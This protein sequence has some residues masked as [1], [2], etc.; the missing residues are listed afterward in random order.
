MATPN[1][2]RNT[3]ALNSDLY[4]TPHWAVA[5]LLKREKFSGLIR[6]PGCGKGDIS[7]VLKM[8][9]HQSVESI[10]LYDWGYGTPNIDYLDLDS[11]VDNT[12]MNPPF[13]LLKEFISKALSTT[14]QKVAVFARVNS[15]ETKDRFNGIYKEKPPTRVYLFVHRVKCNKGGYD[16][17]LSSAVFYCWQVWDLSVDSNVTELHWIDDQCPKEEKPKSVLTA[18]AIH[19]SD[20]K[21]LLDETIAA[22]RTSFCADDMERE[23]IV[24]VSGG[25]DSTVTKAICNIATEGR[26]RAIFCDTDNEHPD[27][28]E[29]I[30]TLH[31]NIGSGSQPVEMYKLEIPESRF[32]YRRKR[33]RETWAKPYVIRQGVYAGEVIPPMTDEQIELAVSLTK[34][35]GNV[36]FDLCI[37]H[38]SM[39]TR[40]ARFCTRELKIEVSQHQVLEIALSECDGEVINWSGVRAE[41]SVKRSTYNWLSEDPR[42]DGFLFTF[43]PIHK[44]KVQDVFALHKY[45]GI[46]P[47]PLY[48]QGA[49]R[50]GCWP[51]IMSNKAEIRQFAQDEEAVQRIAQIERVIKHLNRYSYWRADKEGVPFKDFNTGFF[52]PRAGMV[53]VGIH[54]VIKWAMTDRKGEP[55]EYDGSVMNCQFGEHIFCE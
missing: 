47:N 3:D 20:V 30:K 39:P 42:G 7:K 25:K 36:F 31:D 18:P 49:D 48:L 46:E 33:I 5:A 43:L 13:S 28:Y 41:E 35:T 51:C 27:T 53:G 26:Y 14:N 8:T 21:T 24:S 16:N 19:F 38:G 45:L 2:K 15:L 29:Y 22:Y 11:L 44:W 23:H 52:I 1:T 6:D 32:E 34:P 9:G 55:I 10:D 4:T 17:G 50:V 12:I 40:L 54:D 37:V